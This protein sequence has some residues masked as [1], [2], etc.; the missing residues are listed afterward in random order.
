MDPRRNVLIHML[1]YDPF[2]IYLH[3]HNHVSPLSG[4]QEV[5]AYEGQDEGDIWKV[6]CLEK[7]DKKWT[8]ENKVRLLHEISGKYLSGSARHIFRNPIPGQ[9]EISGTDSVGADEVWTATEGIY[10][11]DSTMVEE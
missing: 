11:P 2:R 10:F 7:N 6:L 5:S 8:R 3:S 9:I 4:G 1:L